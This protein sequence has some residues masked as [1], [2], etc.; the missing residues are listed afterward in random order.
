MNAGSRGHS[1]LARPVSVRRSSCLDFICFFNFG[2][3]VKTEMN[4]LFCSAGVQA[5]GGPHKFADCLLVPGLLFPP[6]ISL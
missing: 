1:N 6:R 4:E 2:F 3:Y 5:G